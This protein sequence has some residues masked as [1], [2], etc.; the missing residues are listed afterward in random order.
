MARKHAVAG[1][2]RKKWWYGLGAA[3]IVVLFF[4]GFDFLTSGSLTWSVW[5]IG[6]VIFF[7][8]MFT[9]LNRFGR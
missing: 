9:L 6:A 4:L 2:K 8:V 5:P 1:R 3:F 7:A